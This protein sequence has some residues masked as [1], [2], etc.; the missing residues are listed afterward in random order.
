V[1]RRQF[2]CTTAASAAA[3]T[4][5]ASAIVGTAR[6]QQSGGATTPG[7]AILIKGGCVLTLDRAVGDFEQADVLVEGG[8]ISAVR[9]NI[10]TRHGLSRGTDETTNPFPSARGSSASLTA[11]PPMPVMDMPA[12]SSTSDSAMATYPAGVSTN[13]G[14]T[15]RNGRPGSPR[16]I[17]LSVVSEYCVSALLDSPPAQQR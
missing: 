1:S 6:A 3:A 9:P 7:R 12:Q 2:L 11:G 5:V 14:S 16:G 10:S 17:A 4:T 15:L 13:N 8:K